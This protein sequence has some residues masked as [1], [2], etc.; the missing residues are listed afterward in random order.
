MCN[1]LASKGWEVEPTLSWFALPNE[2]RLCRQLRDHQSLYVGSL[3]SGDIIYVVLQPKKLPLRKTMTWLCSV[4][5]KT[6][7]SCFDSK[8][9]WVEV[10]LKKKKNYLKKFSDIIVFCLQRHKSFVIL[11]TRLWE[12]FINITFIYC[13]ASNILCKSEQLDRKCTNFCS[14]LPDNE[15]GPQVKKHTTLMWPNI[16]SK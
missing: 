12:R 8:V 2:G 9:I 10:A 16:A 1:T 6:M 4:S 13:S 14:S 7:N 15:G 5:R 3:N 11:N